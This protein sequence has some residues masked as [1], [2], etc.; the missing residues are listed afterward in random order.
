MQKRRYQGL[1]LLCRELGMGG[2]KETAV[3]EHSEIAGVGSVVWFQFGLGCGG[4]DRGETFQA[5]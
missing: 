2:A 5:D 3:T 1:S 4:G